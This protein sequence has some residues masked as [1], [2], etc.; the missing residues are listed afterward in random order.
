MAR[1]PVDHAIVTRYCKAFSEPPKRPDARMI[2]D[3]LEV[4]RSMRDFQ[5]IISVVGINET[6]LRRIGPAAA[7]LARA[8]G[9]E[10]HAR[11]VESRLLGKNHEPV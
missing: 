11:A 8:E 5:N 6:A 7:T 10:A 3:L 2:S 1:L 4:Y 9:L